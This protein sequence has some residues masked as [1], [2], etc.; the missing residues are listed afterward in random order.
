MYVSAVEQR[1]VARADGADLHGAAA[2]HEPERPQL[3]VHP[4]GAAHAGAAHAARLRLL[5]RQTVSTHNVR[6]SA[7][8]SR[9]R[10]HFLLQNVWPQDLVWSAGT[11]ETS[12][13]LNVHRTVQSPPH[14][15]SHE[16]PV[17]VQ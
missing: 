11:W 7:Q 2:S 8:T 4:A 14:R 12:A 16:L 3:L 6:T 5:P 1:A 13:P 15:L 17:F 10:H 9:T